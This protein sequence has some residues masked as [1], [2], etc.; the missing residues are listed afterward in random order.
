MGK[1]RE[2][3]EKALEAIGGVENITYVTNC[4]TRLRINYASKSK[5]DEE[6]L[7]NL[8]G[9]AGLV[10]KPGN[11]QYQIIIGPNVRDAYY[12][13]LDVS[14]WKEGGPAP[15]GADDPI[16]DE[17]EKKEDL[18]IM[19]ENTIDFL[20]QNIYSRNLVKPNTSGVTAFTVNNKG[21]NDGTGKTARETRAIEGWFETDRDP[22]TKLNP[23]GREIYPRCAYV[24][25]TKRKERYGDIPIYVTE[26]GHGMYE[27]VD[28]NGEI[29]D[30]ARIDFLENYLYWI[31]KAKE[32]GVNV[33]GYYVWSNTDLYSWINGYKKRYGLVFVDYE[34]K[35][36]KR[37]PKKSYYWYKEY[38]RKY[39]ENM[40]S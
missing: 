38:I 28:E 5:V 32:E 26:N 27:Y 34:D 18:E 36:L 22:N 12:E 35:N 37:I 33:K 3:C 10:P 25:L 17:P 11:K 4:A 13:F 39:M 14:G 31:M 21:N 8:P 6:A 40:D 24:T 9:S 23:W 29:N 19:K 15:A 20:G 30:D 16:D 1:Y 7:K 2:L